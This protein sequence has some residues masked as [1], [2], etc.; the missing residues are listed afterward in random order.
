MQ[1][2]SSLVDDTFDA[3]AGRGVPGE[4]ERRDVGRR[5]S[6]RRASPPRRR[7]RAEPGRM[8]RRREQHDEREPRQP[9]MAEIG[10]EQHRRDEIVRPQVGQRAL[11]HARRLHH[12]RGAGGDHGEHEASPGK[13]RQPARDQ[14]RHR[15]VARR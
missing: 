15:G 10:V 7:R 13:P 2:V 12:Q 11:A 4:G 14:A 8:E 9:H 3:V 5:Q 6:Q 1:Y